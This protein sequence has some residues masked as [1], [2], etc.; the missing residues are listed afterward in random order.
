MYSYSY[1][2]DCDDHH[3]HHSQKTK[4]ILLSNTFI[5]KAIIKRKGNGVRMPDSVKLVVK[6][7]KKKGAL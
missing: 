6:F 2:K 5:N 3:H 4:N 1:N 7:K